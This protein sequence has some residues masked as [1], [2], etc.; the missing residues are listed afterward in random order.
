MPSNG[1]VL[2]KKGISVTIT[3]MISLLVGNID[4][5]D[6]VV[7]IL[8]VPEVTSSWW[9][10]LDHHSARGN[11]ILLDPIDTQPSGHHTSILSPHPPRALNYIT[12]T[13]RQLAGKY[14][15][16]IPN[17]HT[18]KKTKRQHLIKWRVNWRSRV[19]LQSFDLAFCQS[20]L[21]D[22]LYIL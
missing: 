2:K 14:K 22:I 4:D 21:H 18:K 20:I 8:I 17:T 10:C 3:T 11:L 9:C 6:D 13:C 5:L 7:L 15:T 16:Q 19:L 12:G 1:F